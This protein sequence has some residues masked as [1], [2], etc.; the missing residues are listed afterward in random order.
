MQHERRTDAAPRE[1]PR[2][3]RTVAAIPGLASIPAYVDSEEQQELLL[4]VDAAPG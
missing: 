1:R 2:P 4:G 3:W